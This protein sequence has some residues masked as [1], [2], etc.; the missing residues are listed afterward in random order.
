ML[1][2]DFDF[3]SIKAV[4]KQCWTYKSDGNTPIRTG[5]NLYPLEVILENDAFKGFFVEIIHHR[6]SYYTDTFILWNDLGNSCVKF[7]SINA[8][9]DLNQAQEE[10]QNLFKWKGIDGFKV[11]LC[12]LEESHN[13]IRN[14]S[15]LAL[16]DN[17][18]TELAIHYQ[19]YHDR[20]KTEREEE[21]RLQR[22]EYGR[23]ERKKE[24]ERQAEIST[25]LNQA[26]QNIREKK[27]LKNELIDGRSIVLCL[28][29]RYGIRVPI[30]TQ[31]WFNQKLAFVKWIDGGIT[32]SY[33]KT[34]GTNGSQ[35]AFKY[36]NMLE[37]AVNA[38]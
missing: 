20:F 18:E 2:K 34:K 6:E 4:R 38:V 26:E 23:Q 30:K 3:T 17:G 16:A 28:M 24:Q 5:K 13:W 27:D 1:I 7:G 15:I 32:Y 29:D 19:E 11:W 36:L 8:Y 35:T 37:E 33:Y 14:T 9:F 21:E 22:E 10:L 25:Q 31:G 12:T